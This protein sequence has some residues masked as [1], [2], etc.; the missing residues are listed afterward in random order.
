[1]GWR[2]GGGTGS[3]GVMSFVADFN[4]AVRK[5]DEKVL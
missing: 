5:C 3:C 2:G 4:D 1:M